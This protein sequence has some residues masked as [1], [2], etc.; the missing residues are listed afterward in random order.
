MSK[1]SEKISRFWEKMKTFLRSSEDTIEQTV[2]S[3]FSQIF[4][5][6]SN[7]VPFGVILQIA[8]LGSYVSPKLYHLYKYRDFSLDVDAN[9]VQERIEDNDKD[10]RLIRDHG[11]RPQR[12]LMIN[13]DVFGQ[14]GDRLLLRCSDGIQIKFV[15]KDGPVSFDE[16]AGIADIGNVDPNEKGVKFRIKLIQEG[17]IG[18]KNPVLF[19]KDAKTDRI[20]CQKNIIEVPIS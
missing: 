11:K 3:F 18:I 8:A 9:P 12:D 10:I 7:L 17:V 15:D 5:I 14:G 13:V 16:D 6:G 4:W 2:G 19:I 1:P 20:L